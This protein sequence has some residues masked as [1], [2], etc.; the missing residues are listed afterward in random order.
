MISISA[1][2]PVVVQDPCVPN[3]C[4]P[5]SERPVNTGDRC[6]CRCQRGMIGSPPN[7]RPE[8]ILNSDCS[9]SLACQSQK[10]QDPCPGLCGYN[11]HCRVRNHIP[12]CMCDKG[13]VGDPFVN[14]NKIT[15]RRPIETIHPCNPSPCGI[16][17]HCSEKGQAAACNCIDDYIGNPYIECKPECVV[18]A[19]CASHLACVAQK[20]KDPCPGVCGAHASC[21]T[22][23]HLP[24][25]NC[26]PGY[27]GD[28]FVNCY[29]ITTR[30]F[31]DE[32]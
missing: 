17:A 12:M 11:A 10:C 18:S 21:S 26:D 2:E 22:R 31:K 15:T 1:T 8:C 16:N 25:C 30:E 13:Y 28:P 3:P 24:Q 29:R 32:D 20:C 5:H 6:D 9:E 7:C 19:E 27:E 4:G 23:N 14:C